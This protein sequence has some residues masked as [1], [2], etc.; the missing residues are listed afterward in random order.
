LGIANR[1]TDIISK[2]VT[3]FGLSPA[4]RSRISVNPDSVKKSDWDSMFEEEKTKEPPE[5]KD[6]TTLQ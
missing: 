4:S 5:V 6:G 3:E 2:F 1:S